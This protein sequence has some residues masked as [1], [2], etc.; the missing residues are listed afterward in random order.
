MLL[1][2]RHLNNRTAWR[3]SG[4]FAPQSG[5]MS[6]VNVT[7]RE[8]GFGRRVAVPRGYGKKALAPPVESGQVSS[9]G[10]CRIQIDAAGVGA[11]GR[12]VTGQAV[13]T[14]EATLAGGL[15]VSA[16]GSA[17]LA[18]DATLAPSG[19]LTASGTAALAITATAAVYGI[20][21]VTGQAVLSITG[22]LQP[23]GIGYVRGTTDI[24]V[25][26][27]DVPRQVWTYLAAAANDPGTMGAK[28]NAAGSGGVDT[29]ALAD[30]IL[31][32]SLA[33]GA[34]GGRTVRDALRASRNRVVISGSTLTV[35]AEDDTTVAW[36]ATISTAQ[37]DPL[38]GVD[39][40]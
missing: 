13:L 20:A 32:R 16:T 19:V 36:T 8:S 24:Q 28:L 15:V 31:A 6:H 14:I 17:S 29:G 12:Q 9:F 18:I 2:N 11:L 25:G 10:R 35:Y 22:T 37:R 5:L 39:P 33:G 26:L 3:H 27:A 7:L 38:Q 30:A 34:D 21:Q 1:G 4:A 40:A 23:L